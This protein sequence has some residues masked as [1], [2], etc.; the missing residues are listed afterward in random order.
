MITFFKL[1]YLITNFIVHILKEIPE[2]KTYITF[3]IQ[4]QVLTFY[5]KNNNYTFEYAK[6]IKELY[7][8][9]EYE[10]VHNYTKEKY[11]K[12]DYT[13][14]NFFDYIKDHLKNKRAKVFDIAFASGLISVHSVM[15]LFFDHLKGNRKN[16]GKSFKKDIMFEPLKNI[17]TEKGL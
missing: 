8:N 5:N 16:E 4:K 1:F 12:V 9:G 11:Y 13:D 14:Y 15:S 10:C 17:H 6:M 2:M 7:D 3:F